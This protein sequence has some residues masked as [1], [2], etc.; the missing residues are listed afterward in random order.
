MTTYET[1]DRDMMT[2]ESS[3]VFS[4]AAN[5]TTDSYDEHGNL[6][7][8]TDPRG[9]AVVRQFDPA[10]RTDPRTRSGG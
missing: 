2:E 9:V 7:L 1:G 10:D 4:G 8:N 6:S 3:P 5:F